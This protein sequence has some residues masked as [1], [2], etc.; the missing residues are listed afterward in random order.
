VIANVF[1]LVLGVGADSDLFWST[2]LRV[3]LVLKFGRYSSPLQEGER[4][5]EHSKRCCMYVCVMSFIGCAFY[6]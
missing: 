6:D 5:G 4:S 1:N 2:R 3:L